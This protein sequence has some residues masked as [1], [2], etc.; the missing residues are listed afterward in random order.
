M[1]EISAVPSRDDIIE[2]LGA[3]LVKVAAREPASL[4]LTE[5]ARLRDDLGLDSFAAVELIFELEDMVDVRITREAAATFQT[6]GDV[7]SYVMDEL[8]A[9]RARVAAG[10]PG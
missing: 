5:S 10:Q 3:A 4:S 9:A 1:T 7:V 8:S 6:V 2:K